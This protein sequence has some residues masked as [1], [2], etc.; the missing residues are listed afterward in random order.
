[1]NAEAATQSTGRPRRFLALVLA[2]IGLVLMAGGLKLALLGGSLSYLAAGITVAATA[3]LAFKGDRRD[4]SLYAILLG[5]T[6]LWALWEGG[7]DVWRLQ[8]RLLAPLVL[9]VVLWRRR[10][11]T[12]PAAAGAKR[13]SPIP[14]FILGFL[15]CVAIGSTGLVPAPALAAA[16]QLDIA[17]LTA[18]L[19]GLGLGVSARHII[20]LGWRPMAL[21]A[22]A[23]M[24]AALSSL[25]AVLLL[26]E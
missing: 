11:N 17:L 26:V 6:L 23:W 24:A 22:G 15:A 9:G 4:A 10:C 3:W 20:R 1:M 25:A 12:T 13:T 19:V 18:A 8:S 14:V 21:G 5:A 16:Q 2:A 7:L